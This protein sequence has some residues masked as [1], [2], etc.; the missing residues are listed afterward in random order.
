MG[1]L[2]FVGLGLH[3]ERDLTLRA[4]EELRS[5]DEVLAEQY[6]SRW[7]EGAMGRLSATLGQKIVQL[8]RE[9]VEG[10]ARIL[11]ALE[12]H[13][14]VALL[15][16]GEPFAAT[17][18]VALRLAVER[19]G[20]RWSLV[21]NASILTAAASL[22]GLSHYRFGRTVSLPRP[23]ADYRPTSPYEAILANRRAG[24]H[25]LV[26]LDLNP[27]AGSYLRADEALKVLGAIEDERK[28]GVL[29]P[30]REV[31]VVARA[32]GPDATVTVG[33][34][35]V[36]ER[37]DFGPPLHCLIVPAPSLHFVEEE[38]LRGRRVDAATS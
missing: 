2:V 29:P 33:P 22:A 36:L 7:G 8:S 23:T 12:A 37:K 21:H 24:A 28:E 27:T 3:D 4:L 32:G 9:E 34:R 19:H 6:T 15:V 38:A 18:H 14:R 17:T 25:S 35:R 30:E 13:A 11:S 26:L 16:V 10:E 31:V 5:C 20:H 1:E